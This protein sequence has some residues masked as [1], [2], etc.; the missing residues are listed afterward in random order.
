MEDYA[1][2]LRDV[3]SHAMTVEIDEGV[4]RSIRF[5]DPGRWH[6]HFRLTTWPGYLCISGDMGTFVFSRLNDMFEF[7]RDAHGENRINLS[8][9]AEKLQA[10]SKAEGYKGFAEDR[11]RARVLEAVAEWDIP[12]EAD[13]ARA[14]AALEDDWDGLLG[15]MPLSEA[16]AIKAAMDW[17]CPVTGNEFSDAWEWRVWDYSYHFTWCCR[18]IVW[19]IKRYDLAKAGR[20]QGSHDRDVLAGAL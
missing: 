3:S 19:G 16:E 1:R 4:H 13:R 8:Y 10:T 20:D 5:R 6:L 17:T 11:F 14:I 15:A 18:A 7:F 9:W 2:F 12:D